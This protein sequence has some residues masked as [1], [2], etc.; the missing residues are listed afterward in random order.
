[1]RTAVTRD[2]GNIKKSSNHKAQAKKKKRRFISVCQ[3]VSFKNTPLLCQRDHSSSKRAIPHFQAFP[4]CYLL[5]WTAS[6]S[7]CEPYT[8]CPPTPLC[9]C[10]R[11]PVYDKHKDD[12]HPQSC[13]WVKKIYIFREVC[14]RCISFGRNPRKQP[15]TERSV[16][17]NKKNTYLMC[18]RGTVD[19]TP[20]K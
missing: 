18:Q 9:V 13:V 15:A 19:P 1:M 2:Y 8:S 20:G 10:A 5:T 7:K 6:H 11:A 16:M 4:A 17:K 3:A 14:I 12:C